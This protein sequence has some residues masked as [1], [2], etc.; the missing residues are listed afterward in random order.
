MQRQVR[1]CKVCQENAAVVVCCTCIGILCT[2]CAQDH[3]CHA[4]LTSGFGGGGHMGGFGGGHMGGFGGGG[5]HMGGF[6]HMGGGGGHTGGGHTG[7]GGHMGGGHTGGGH[8][9]GGHSGRHGGGVGSRYFYGGRW[10]PWWG[11]YGGGFYLWSIFGYSVFTAA[12]LEAQYAQQQRALREIEENEE[13]AKLSEGAAQLRRKLDEA[14]QLNT[15]QAARKY[16]VALE[17]FHE[18]VEARKDLLASQTPE[19]ED[20]DGD[21]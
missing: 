13:D 2:A 14:R 16:K 1:N 7:G 18:A 4:A 20:A 17:R 15:D 6:G 3:S 12:L 19:E 11:W 9:G 10:W 8:T 21:E 5:G